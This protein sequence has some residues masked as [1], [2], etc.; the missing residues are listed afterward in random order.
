MRIPVLL[1][2]A[3]LAA[4]TAT[5][6]D[7]AAELIESAVAG[8]HR[9]AANVARDRYRHPAETLAFFGW[10]PEMTVLEVSPGTGWYTEILAPMT[11]PNGILYAANF[12]LLADDLPPYGERVQRMF[13]DLLAAHPEVYDHVVVTELSVPQRVT[14]APPGSVDMALV[15]R[16]VHSWM[17]AGEAAETVAVL[18]R[19]LKP[20]GILGVVQH[21]AP[22]GR[23]VEQMKETGY[24]TEQHVID[25]MQTAGFE[26]VDRAQI[27]ANPKDTKDHP[28][29]VWS[30]PPSLRGCGGI[31]DAAQKSACE[32][33][34]RAIGESDRMTLK[35]RKPA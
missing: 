3:V 17:R 11:R 14:P 18:H 5:A 30:L 34:Y 9:Q 27:N 25:L 31:E 32:E 4:Q 1:I 33:K 13:L 7:H 26:L 24:V 15:F 16:N 8:D 2:T 20:G 21:R 29:G 19:M 35:F 28:Q 10:Q 6:A 22:E 23:S 12:A